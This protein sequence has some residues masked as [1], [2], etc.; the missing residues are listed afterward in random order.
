MRSKPG[1]Y[2]MDK[3]TNKIVT[4]RTD[5]FL[6]KAETYSQWKKNSRTAKQ[7]GKGTVMKLDRTDLFIMACIV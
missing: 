1:V 7:E 4:V 6:S 3:L 5:K 2:D